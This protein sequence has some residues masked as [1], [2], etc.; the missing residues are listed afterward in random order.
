MQS[1]V[2][3]QASKSLS[4]SVI[5]T[6]SSYSMPWVSRNMHYDIMDV[7]SSGS[8]TLIDTGNSGSSSSIMEL[9]TKSSAVP[10]ISSKDRS[11]FETTPSPPSTALMLPLLDPTQLEVFLPYLTL[12]FILINHK[13]TI[14][15]KECKLDYTQVLFQGNIMQPT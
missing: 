7:T 8:T 3:N 13:L 4:T 1:Q 14:L 10:F 2:E 15:C 12:L 9:G 5:V 11:E 6:L